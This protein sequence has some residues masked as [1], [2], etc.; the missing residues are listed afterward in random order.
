MDVNRMSIIALSAAVI[1]IAVAFL[2]HIFL[3]SH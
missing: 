2:G 1:L 3:G